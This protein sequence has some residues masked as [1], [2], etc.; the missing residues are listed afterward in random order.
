MS[1]SED[2][3]ASFDDRIRQGAVFDARR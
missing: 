3:F 1:M 2:E